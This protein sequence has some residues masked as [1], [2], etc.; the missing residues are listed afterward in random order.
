MMVNAKKF[1]ENVIPLHVLIAVKS[2]LNSKPSTFDVQLCVR[3]KTYLKAFREFLHDHER[4]GK[5]WNCRSFFETH[6]KD[7]QNKDAFWKQQK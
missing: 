2:F 7:A 1:S 3:P 5:I 4:K 6:S